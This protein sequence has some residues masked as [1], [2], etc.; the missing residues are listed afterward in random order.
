MNYI[1]IGFI[2]VIFSYRSCRHQQIIVN[3]SLSQDRNDRFLLIETVT[4]QRLAL[5][6]NKSELFKISGMPHLDLFNNKDLFLFIFCHFCPAELK[7]FDG[8]EFR[9]TSAGQIRQN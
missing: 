3:G 8:I 1:A 4:E 5:A 9:R 7:S 2:V 6:T